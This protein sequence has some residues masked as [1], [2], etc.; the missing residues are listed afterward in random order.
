MAKG[1]AVA[2][3]LTGSPMFVTAMVPAVIDYSGSFRFSVPPQLV[4]NALEQ[5]GDFERWWGW[6]GKFRLVG[7][8]LQ[9]GSVLAGVV[10]PPLFYQM[11][12]RVELEDC[13][14]PSS[15]DAAIHGDLEGRA[16]VRLVPQLPAEG[17][18]AV[19][20]VPATVVSMNWTVEMMQRPMRIAA[21][22]AYPLVHWAHGQAVEA[23]VLE[24]RRRIE[25]QR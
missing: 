7:D 1:I 24:F 8:G 18:P 16:S 22:V 10:S 25:D 23:T 17:P 13:V 11:R 12:V 21:R 5:T 15:I 19:G 14:R 4:W 2:K 9:A 20:D 6:L 3:G